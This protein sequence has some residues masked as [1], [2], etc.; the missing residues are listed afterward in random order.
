M[1]V[2]EYGICA[3]CGNLPMFNEEGCPDCDGPN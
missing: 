3:T 2:D 1:K